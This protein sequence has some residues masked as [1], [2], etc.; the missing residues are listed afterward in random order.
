M[1]AEDI[2]TP[3]GTIRLQKG[4]VAETL[5]TGKDGSAISKE[6]FLGTYLVKETKQPDGY[7]LNKKEYEITLK[8]QDQETPVVEAEV[9]P[10]APT[11][12]QC[13][14]RKGH[15]QAHSRSQIPDLEQSYV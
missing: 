10:N 5:T 4:E 8:Y 6:L 1:A 15:R 11:K 13:K 3:D 12:I 9:I 7:L 2:V 14:K